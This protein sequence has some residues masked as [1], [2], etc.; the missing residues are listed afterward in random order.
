MV[1]P[2]FESLGYMKL[3]SQDTTS[4]EGISE[5]STESD[6]RRSSEELVVD[7]VMTIM[8]SIECILL[9]GQLDQI[10]ERSSE[11]GAINARIE[12]IEEHIAILDSTLDRAF[13]KFDSIKSR[14]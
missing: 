9:E 13:E 8:P 5:I 3:T 12:S 1:P 4:E 6:K 11:I 2:D 10:K 14:F 7:L